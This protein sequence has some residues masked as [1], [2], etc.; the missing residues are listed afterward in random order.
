MLPSHPC[1]GREQEGKDV[2]SFLKQRCTEPELPITTA[3]ISLFMLRALINPE[4]EQGCLITC[5]VAPGEG[6][7]GTTVM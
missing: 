3:P 6:K 7:E 2:E 4:V 1:Y 5:Q